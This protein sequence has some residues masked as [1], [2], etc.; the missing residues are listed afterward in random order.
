[1]PCISLIALTL[2]YFDMTFLGLILDGNTIPHFL[3]HTL[4]KWNSE[5]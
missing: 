5:R 3:L 2:F 1:M 4:H